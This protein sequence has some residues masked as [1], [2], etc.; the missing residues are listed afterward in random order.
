[1]KSLVGRFLVVETGWCEAHKQYEGG[2]L[3]QFVPTMTI[4]NPAHKY[5]PGSEITMLDGKKAKVIRQVG[6]YNGL[7]SWLMSQ[8]INT[9]TGE[10]PA[11]QSLWDVMDEA[12]QHGKD[13]QRLKAQQTIQALKD[14]NLRAEDDLKNNL[15]EARRKLAEANGRAAN[16]QKTIKALQA[17]IAAAT[18]PPTTT[19]A[20]EPALATTEPALEPVT[21][22]TSGGNGESGNNGQ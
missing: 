10:V 21:A 12:Y 20:A 16:A 2:R 14:T 3:L 17:Q 6:D 15:S 1:M 5:V 19:P 22:A 9:N 11:M 13:D 18:Q 7:L 4:E 8:T